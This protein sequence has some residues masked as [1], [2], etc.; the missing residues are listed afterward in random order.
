MHADIE[1]KSNVLC[2]EAFYFTFSST[3]NTK[4]IIKN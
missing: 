1:D 2:N 3:S 4:I